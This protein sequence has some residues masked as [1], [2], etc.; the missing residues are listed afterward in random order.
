MELMKN[1]AKWAVNAAQAFSVVSTL[2]ATV[3]FATRSTV[4]GGYDNMGY[5]ILRHKSALFK[6]FSYCEL[7]AL[8]FSFISTLLFLSIATSSP[9]SFRMENEAQRLDG[10][11]TYMFISIAL[12]WI[13]F[14][15]GHYFT[16]DHKQ[17][18]KMDYAILAYI[19]LSF[20]IFIFFLDFLPKFVAPVLSRYKHDPKSRF[21]VTPPIEY[22]RT[23]NKESIMKMSLEED[24]SS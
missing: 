9:Q 4:P 11:M 1:D 5:A 15:A 2:V 24:S 23:K 22:R 20:F 13:S 8:A 6:V 12:L 18:G 17:H 10:G 3:A 19:F 7:L 16:L 14:C 21:K